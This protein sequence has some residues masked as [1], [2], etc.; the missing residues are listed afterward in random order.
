MCFEGGCGSCVVSFSH[1][2]AFTKKVRR[3]SVNSC[4]CFL[5]SCHGWDIETNEGIGNKKTGYHVLQ[6]RLAH[7]NGTQCGYC[8]SGMVMNMYR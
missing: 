3:F 5:H 1:R 4:L 8:S 7:F 6:T 2:N